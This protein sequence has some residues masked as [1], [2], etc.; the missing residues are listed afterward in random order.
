MTRRKKHIEEGGGFI[1]DSFKNFANKTR[2]IAN[3]VIYGRIELPPKVQ[4]ILRE[5]GD[6]IINGVII[7]RTKINTLTTGV[8]KILSKTPYD[9]LYHLFLILNTNKGN[10]L[11]KIMNL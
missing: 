6:A 7:G 5:V 8:I 9:K 11:Q 3:K 4:N 1:S 10:L 2:D